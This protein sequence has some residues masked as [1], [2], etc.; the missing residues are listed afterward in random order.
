V[1]AVAELL[2]RIDL[3]D[4]MKL[5]DP[6]Y[7]NIRWLELMSEVTPRIEQFGGVL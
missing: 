6:R 4:R 1:D 3:N 2:S 5:S 7:Y